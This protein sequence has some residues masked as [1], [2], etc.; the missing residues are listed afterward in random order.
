MPTVFITGASRGIGR[1]IAEYLGDK[2]YELGLIAHNPARLENTENELREAGIRVATAAAD[3]TDYE[4][5]EQAVAKLVGEL[6]VP[7]LVVNNAGRIDAEVPVWEADPVEWKSVLDTNLLGAFNIE[8][9]VLPLMLE[10][11]GGRVINMVTGAGTKDWG[12]FTAYTSSKAGLIR[13]VGDLHVS[14]YDLGL[15]AFGIAPGTVETDM[16]TSMELHANR[17]DFTPIE[18]TL[19]LV[20][21]IAEGKLD[22]WSGAYLRATDDTV[23]SLEA[24]AHHR[25]DD[26]QVRSLGIISWGED[27]PLN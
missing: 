19:D 5:V 11:G 4:A 8:R 17:T 21:G 26:G 16:A 1:A 12:I 10:N 2:G 23:E 13:N 18:K 15:R 20:G 22:A 27:D 7:N 14:G 3:V 25:A 24:A 9:V 6:G